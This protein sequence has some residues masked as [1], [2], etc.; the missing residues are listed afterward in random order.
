[1]LKC[2]GIAAVFVNLCEFDIQ[3]DIFQECMEALNETI[4]PLFKL[5]LSLLKI[6]WKKV[7]DPSTTIIFL[8]I[9]I[10]S[11]ALCLRLTGE[12]IIHFREELCRF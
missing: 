5:D 2:H 3:A 10:D 8:G 1:M 6:N 7:V 12:K 11:V 9:E 4:A